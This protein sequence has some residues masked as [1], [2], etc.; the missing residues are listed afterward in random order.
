MKLREILQK[1]V[2]EGNLPNLR[3]GNG[4]TDPATLLR[5][6]SSP[7]LERPAYLQPGMYIAE[8]NE[9]GYLGQV[10]FRFTDKV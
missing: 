9:A 3:N 1:L 5:Q 4:A 10:L 8:I 7:M 6:L 2:Q